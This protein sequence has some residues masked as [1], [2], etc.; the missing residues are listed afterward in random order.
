VEL[1]A[2]NRIVDVM[3][4]PVAIAYNETSSSTS[5]SVGADDHEAKGAT[6]RIDF[7]QPFSLRVSTKQHLMY[8]M[9]LFYLIRFSMTY[10]I[11]Q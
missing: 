3:I 11:C 10:Y 7:D 1:I 8:L 2:K 5:S 9:L 6:A 4:V